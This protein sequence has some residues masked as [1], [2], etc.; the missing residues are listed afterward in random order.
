MTSVDLSAYARDG[1]LVLEGFVPQAEC[2][3]LQARATELAAGFAPGPAHTTFS[4]RDQRHARDLYFRESGGAVRFFVEEGAPDLLNKIGHALHDLDPVFERFS[5]HRRLEEL[6]RQLGLVEPRLLQSMYLF[7]HAH[8]GAEVDWHQDATYLRTDPPSVTGF[9]IALDDA[10]RD[11]GCL[12][13]LP[14]AHRGPLRQWFGYEGDEL[15]TRSLDAAPWPAAGLAPVWIVAL[16]VNL[17][18]ALNHSLRWVRPHPAWA[19][20]LGAIAAPLSYLGA[21]R[22]WDA[23]AFAEPLWRT[24]GIVAVCWAVMMA[25]LVAIARHGARIPSVANAEAA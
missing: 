7:K 8:V 5:R 6:A 3:A 23:V 13:A 17:A 4:T 9:W 10:D 14:G 11:N 24:L 21:A 18:L 16:W 2:D 15:V 19:A 12:M 22:G 25:I 20:A 1:F